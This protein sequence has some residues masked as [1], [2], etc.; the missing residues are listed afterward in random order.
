MKTKTRLGQ[1]F[2][3]DGASI[4]RIVEAAQID[5]ED[6]VVEIGPG[7]GALTGLLIEQSDRVV[8]I[9]VDRDLCDLLSNRFGSR[10]KIVS[11]DVRRVNLPA[12]VG[13]EKREKVVLV[14]N[15]P[16]HITGA[17]IRQITDARRVWKRAVITVQREVGQ[18][19]IA[20]PGSKI[21][22]VLSIVTQVRCVA[23]RLFDLPPAH[24]YPPPKVH[25]SVL[26]LD[27]EANSAYDIADERRLFGVVRAAFQQRRK[28]VR[29]ALAGLVDD[30]I[31]IEANIDGRARPET[32]SIDGFERICRALAMR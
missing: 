16:Y 27:F 31:L 23:K 2:L 22:G 5:K 20:P 29:N 4:E 24:F 1:H 30:E 9:E 7:R 17:L 21:Y 6:L 19:M 25:S 18:R 32:I 10:L 26:V 28:M 3:T 12:L 14:G 11:D 8:A 13:I 15:L